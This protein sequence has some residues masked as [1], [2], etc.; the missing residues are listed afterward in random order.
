MTHF[1][2]IAGQNNALLCTSDVWEWNATVAKACR[3][4]KMSSNNVVRMLQGKSMAVIGDQPAFRTFAAMR[5]IVDP[6]A[7]FRTNA[8]TDIEVDLGSGGFLN[9]RFAETMGD[10]GRRVASDPADVILFGAF[11][12]DLEQ[13]LSP[14][15]FA[16]AVRRICKQN[17]AKTLV[18]LQPT[19]VPNKNMRAIVGDYVQAVEKDV[20]V[21]VI[22]VRAF[23]HS[24]NRLEVSV[25]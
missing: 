9:F 4:K 6:K 14:A 10:V 25:P 8:K 11:T 2:V 23:E 22:T 1:L 12:K 5:R 17:T 19:A 7:G 18:W 20:Q 16:K 13:Q 3:F 15:M 24:V 21:E